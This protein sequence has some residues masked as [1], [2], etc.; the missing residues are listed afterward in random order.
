MVL[1]VHESLPDHLALSPNAFPLPRTSNL[2]YNGR[3]FAGVGVIDRGRTGLVCGG[4]F[5]F[6]PNVD[7]SANCYAYLP[8]VPIGANTRRWHLTKGK[9]AAPRGYQGYSVHPELG[10]VM[11]GGWNKKATLA[12][13]ESTHTGEVFD[14]SLPDMPEAKSGHCQ[15]TVD[16]STI[17][18]FGGHSATGKSSSAFKLDLTVKKWSRIADVPL[19][20]HHLGCG[21]VKRNGTATKV[22]V[23]GGI[24]KS[25]TEDTVD[26]LDLGNFKWTSGKHCS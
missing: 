12:S 10:L 4:V 25:G 26:I 23:Y 17:M 16:N 7:S 14:T 21:L 13:V 6:A 2:N 22:V 3:L 5:P 1:V 19:A 8:F 24:S 11:T 9:M 15:V 18:V 20:R